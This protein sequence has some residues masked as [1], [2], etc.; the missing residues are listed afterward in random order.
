MDSLSPKTVGRVVAALIV[1]FTFEIWNIYFWINDD[2]QTQGHAEESRIQGYIFWP[3]PPPW[4]EGNFFCPNWKTGKNLKEDLKK[5]KE[6]GGKE[7]NKEKSDK[8]HVKIPLWS[9]N[10]CKK[11][12][13]KQGRILERGGKNFSG[14]P[15]YI[16]LYISLCPSAIS[17]VIFFHKNSFN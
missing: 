7:E 10:D 13:Q 12:P 6:K 11:N 1:L 2:W 17:F 14:W 8:T 9:L 5:G 16:P 3:S 4:G 15:E